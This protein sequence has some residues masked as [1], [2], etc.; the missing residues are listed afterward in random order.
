M[1][2]PYIA[3]KID[4]QN[5]FY[6]ASIRYG[7]SDNTISPIGTYTDSFDTTRWMASGKLSGQYKHGDITIRPKASVTWYEET[8]E[9]YTDSLSN[10]ISETTVSLGEFRFGPSF[11]QTMTLDNGTIFTPSFGLA[12]VY[13]FDL[14]DNAASQATTLGDDQLRARVDAGFSA[15]NPDNGITLSLSAYYD[16]IF[17]T[18][19]EAYG[20]RARITVPLN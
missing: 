16:G 14:N 6:E 3:G 11:E 9:A 4:G 18:D 7:Q 17:I 12:G 10:A 5:L 13:N 8:Q 1:V 20:G 19:Y 15:T 2:G